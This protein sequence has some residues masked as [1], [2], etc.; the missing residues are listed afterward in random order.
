MQAG[1]EQPHSRILHPASHCLHIGPM[2]S[3]AASSGCTAPG[4]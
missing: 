1:R 2:V 4:A 3:S